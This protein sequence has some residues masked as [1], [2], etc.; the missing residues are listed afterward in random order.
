M[1]RMLV[2]MV[3]WLLSF[4][5]IYA[6]QTVRGKVVDKQTQVSIVGASV[7]LMETDPLKGDA[8]DADGFFRIENVIPGRYSIRVS[9]LGY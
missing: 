2:L 5:A 9:Y 1:N 7:T 6:Q 3:A 8:T 4:Q